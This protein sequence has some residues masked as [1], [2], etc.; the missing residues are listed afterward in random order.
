MIAKKKKLTK[1]KVIHAGLQIISAKDTLNIHLSDIA[2]KLDVDVVELYPF[3]QKP[4]DVFSLITRQ[5]NQ[6]LAL[7]YQYDPSIP[8]RD[9]YFDLIMERFDLLQPYK[10]DIAYFIKKAPA[11]PLSLAMFFPN[12]DRGIT[13]MMH[14]AGDIQNNRAR[15]IKRTALIGVYLSTFRVWL[16]DNSSDSAKTMAHLDK[17]LDKLTRLEE[18]IPRRRAA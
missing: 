7:E 6:T 9:Q 16:K 5:V 15:Y 10:T 13:L 18:F 12:F 3:I 14:L 1:Q 8:V 2:E 11:S 4:L 17:A